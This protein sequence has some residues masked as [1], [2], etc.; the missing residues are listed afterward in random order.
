MYMQIPNSFSTF[1]VKEKRPLV[2]WGEFS[3]RLPIKEELEG[4]K[5][6]FGNYQKGIATG[7]VSKILVLD[8]DGGLDLEKYKIPKTWTAKTPRGGKHYFFRWAESLSTK[9]TTRTEIL[10]KL[11]VRGEGG[12]VVHYGFEQLWTLHPLSDPPKWL[13]DLLP[14]KHQEGLLLNND[15]SQIAKIYSESANEAR[16]K[17]KLQET[18][19][20]IHTGNR[21]DSFTRIAGSLRSRGYSSSDIYNLL[22]AKAREVGFSDGELRTVC[23]SVARYE[24]KVKIEELSSKDESF[25]KFLSEKETVSWIHQGLLAD[26]TIN[27]LAGLQESRKSWGILDLALSISTGTEWLGKYLMKQRKVLLIDQERGKLELRRRL[28]ALIAAKQLKV[29]DEFFLSPKVGTT[30]RI[31]QDRSYEAFCKYIEEHKPEVI[32]IDSLKTFQ[33]GDITSN[34]SMQEVFEKLKG[35]RN[36]YNVTFV[37]IHHEH[38]GAYLRDREGHEVTAETIAGASVINEV[39]EGLF[40]MAKKDADSSMLYH[41]KNSYG[42]KQNPIL[43]KVEDTATG[44]EVKG[45]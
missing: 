17:S 32:L 1:P 7:P 29:S 45:Y 19:N 34:Q 8:D 44:I 4:W 14:N 12:Y 28:T 33:T 25:S 15:Y 40:I 38:K 9:V 30:I 27:I 20:A 3:K 6:R 37:L 24:P 23:N 2:N 16:D 41:V 22:I 42:L 18:L 11:D 26:G 31:N 21:N 13:I 39:P 35:I 5:Q 43:V 10:P 36:K